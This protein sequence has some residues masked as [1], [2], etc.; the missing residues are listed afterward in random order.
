[1]PIIK[2]INEK[3][4]N[5]EYFLMIINRNICFEETIKSVRKKIMCKL[6][7]INR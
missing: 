2:S 3:N 1:M 5:Y 4:I 6:N 7:Y